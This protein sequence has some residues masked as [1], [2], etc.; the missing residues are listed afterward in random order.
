MVGSEAKKPGG[1]ALVLLIRLRLMIG[2]P[3]VRRV[4]GRSGIIYPGGSEASISSGSFW[5]AGLN[6]LRFRVVFWLRS[7]GSTG[8]LLACKDKFLLI[9]PVVVLMGSQRGKN[10]FCGGETNL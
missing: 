3:W 5:W 2:A 8:V 7:E 9:L 1:N 4:F 10:D 6:I